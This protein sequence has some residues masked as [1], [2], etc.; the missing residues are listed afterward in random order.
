MVTSAATPEG[1]FFGDADGVVHQGLTGFFDAV[2]YGA[3]EGN[4]IVGVIQPAFSYFGLPGQNKQ[5][6]MVRP[7]FLSTDRPSVSVS[8]VADYAN[9]A[10]S[11]IP[12]YAVSVG[13]LWDVAQWDSAQWGGALTPFQDWA[14][15]AAVGYVGSAY[16]LTSCVGDTFLASIDY[17]FEP[18]GPI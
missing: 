11:G 7:T 16:L 9:A 14:S 1:Y 2:P 8:V 13:A 17:M 6:H 15:V 10:P 12:A 3:S 4:G 5:W 18:G